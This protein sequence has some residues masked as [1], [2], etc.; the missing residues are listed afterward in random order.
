MQTMEAEEWWL[1]AQPLSDG[2]SSVQRSY[3]YKTFT[4]FLLEH[5]TGSRLVYRII[6]M[7]YTNLFKSVVVCTAVAA[8]S[9]YWG[10]SETTRLPSKPKLEKLNKPR[11]VLRMAEFY[12]KGFLVTIATEKKYL[13][14]G[15]LIK[16]LKATIKHLQARD[17]PINPFFLVYYSSYSG[18]QVSV[19]EV[20][21]YSPTHSLLEISFFFWWAKTEPLSNI[22]VSQM[23]KL[24]TI[25][26]RKS[27]LDEEGSDGHLIEPETEYPLKSHKQCYWKLL[28]LHRLTNIVFVDEYSISSHIYKYLSI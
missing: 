8:A 11:P 24:D 3:N 14:K 9:Y 25:S 19:I 17:M 18:E 10:K 20:Y 16:N 12:F 26:E 13:K 28:L 23:T 22:N 1:T 5:Q 21:S 7:E 27:W 15:K 6:I 2:T 4:F